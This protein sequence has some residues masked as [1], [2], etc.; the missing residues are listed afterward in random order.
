MVGLSWRGCLLARTANF[1]RGDKGSATELRSA[2]A[3]FLRQVGQEP[4]HALDVDGLADVTAMAAGAQ[5]PGTLQLFEVERGIGGTYADL[6]GD[7]AG[8]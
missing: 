2:L 4:A 6:V 1:G 3:A 8:R 7:F 5:Q